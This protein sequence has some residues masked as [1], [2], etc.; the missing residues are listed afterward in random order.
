MPN[1]RM[2]WVPASKLIVS[3]SNHGGYIGGH[4]VICEQHG[5]LDVPPGAPNG[6][7]HLKDCPVA[8]QCKLGPDHCVCGGDTAAVRQGCGNWSK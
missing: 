3:D 5:W 4:C 2:V 8:G 7:K 6:I 1:E